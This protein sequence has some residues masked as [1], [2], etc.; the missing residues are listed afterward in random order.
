ME[1]VRTRD[2][3]IIQHIKHLVDLFIENEQITEYDSVKFLQ[4][5]RRNIESKLFFVWVA[6]ENNTE[7]KVDVCGLVVGY[8]GNNLATDF[9]SL[10]TFFGADE[11]IEKNMINEVMNFCKKNAITEIIHITKN[12]TEKFEKFGFVVTNYLMQRRTENGLP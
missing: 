1:I 2:V 6:Y 3:N 10:H 7:E 4:Y 11:N 9:M 5:I 12:G 8:I